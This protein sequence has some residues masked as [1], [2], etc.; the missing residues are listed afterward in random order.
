MNSTPFL[1]NLKTQGG[2]A[3]NPAIIE[4]GNIA[5]SLPTYELTLAGRPVYLSRQEFD[6]LVLLLRRHD[7][8]L[9]REEISQSLWQ[10]NCEASFLRLNTAVH[11]LRVKLAGSSPYLIR[12]V[13]RRGYGLC[14][15]AS[16]LD[17]QTRAETYA[18]SAV[19]DHDSHSTPVRGVLP[20][21]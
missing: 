21:D 9:P 4:L 17:A 16:V 2:P 20:T 13:R 6:L 18:T 14:R 10:C 5:V 1:E 8:V 12:T 19:K 3:P 11:R 7:R 15:L